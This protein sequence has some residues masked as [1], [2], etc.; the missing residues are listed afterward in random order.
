MTFLQTLQSIFY[1]FCCPHIHFYPIEFAEFSP[2]SFS[3]CSFLTTSAKLMLLNLKFLS[4]RVHTLA[5]HNSLHKFNKKAS[6]NITQQTHLSRTQN[7]AFSLQGKQDLEVLKP[8]KVLTK[9]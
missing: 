2:I 3:L 7:V 8:S 4:V 6:H 9:G 5:K 1:H